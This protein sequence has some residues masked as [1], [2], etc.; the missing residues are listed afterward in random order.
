[1]N[2]IKILIAATGATM[3]G[4]YYD[5]NQFIVKLPAD[6]VAF[7]SETAARDKVSELRETGCE[8]SVCYNFCC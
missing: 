5:E 8:F 4:S 1:M 7:E 2:Y 6:G 3:H